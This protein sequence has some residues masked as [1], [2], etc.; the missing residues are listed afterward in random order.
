MLSLYEAAHLGVHGEDILDEAI[1]FTTAHLQSSMA[2]QVIHA[3]RQPLHKGM[4][5]L[6]AR[7][8]ISFSQDH[9][10][11]HNKALLKLAKLDFN[12]VQSLHKIE[13]SEISRS[14]PDHI[15]HVLLINKNLY[16]HTHAYTHIENAQDKTYMINIYANYLNI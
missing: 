16:T 14:P 15:L 7:S 5:R 6:E 2:P 3:L 11:L 13:L 10:P 1:A 8:F 12:H 9:E 4:P